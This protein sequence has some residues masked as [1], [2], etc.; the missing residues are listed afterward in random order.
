MMRWDD[1]R[2]NAQ[3]AGAEWPMPDSIQETYERFVQ[4]AK[5]KNITHLREG[6]QGYAAL[7]EAI[8]RATK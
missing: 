2:Q 4:I 1:M 3:A 7:E 5:K 6:Q 8:K